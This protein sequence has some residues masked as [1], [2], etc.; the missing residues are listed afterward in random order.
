[1]ASKTLIPL[2]FVTRGQCRFSS[3]RCGCCANPVPGNN[4]DDVDCASKELLL[5]SGT[6]GPLDLNLKCNILELPSLSNNNNNKE[7]ESVSNVVLCSGECGEVYCSLKCEKKAW[8]SGHSLL[9]VG[10][11]KSLDHPLCKFK[12]L[13]AQVG[14]EVSFS[15]SLNIYI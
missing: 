4:D 8:E 14:E 6:C 13:S 9:C 15:Y 2:T 1:M 12:Q 11:L 7:K 5:Q 10:P 3:Y